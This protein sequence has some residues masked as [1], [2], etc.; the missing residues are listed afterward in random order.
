GLKVI[1]SKH[2]IGVRGEHFEAMFSVLE[3]G[4][5]S[6]RWAGREMID[7]V[8]RP[9]FWR[10]PVDNDQGNQMPKRYAQWKIASMYV[11]H[12]DFREGV[13]CKVFVPETEVKEESVKVTYTY[14]M[15]T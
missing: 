3:G 5:V 7:E 1:Q 13:C 4:L 2:N 14:I 6:Y 15:P 8:P 10:A 11:G 9:N 12:K